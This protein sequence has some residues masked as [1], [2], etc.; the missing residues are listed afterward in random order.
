VSHYELRDEHPLNRI[1]RLDVEHPGEH[2]SA[3]L[4]D[5]G[6]VAP[7]KLTL[8]LR[9]TLAFCSRKGKRLGAPLRLD[10]SVINAP[11]MRVA[12]LGFAKSDG[13]TLLVN[14]A[15]HRWHLINFHPP[16]PECW[17]GLFY[18]SAAP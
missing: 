11:V 18:L 4:A 6:L 3:R 8:S 12:V 15:H 14:S 9:G 7:I 2:R 13:Y 5:L 16:Q 1:G 17:G 10:H